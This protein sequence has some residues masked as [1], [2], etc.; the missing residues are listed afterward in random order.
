MGRLGYSHLS[1]LGNGRG[2]PATEEIITVSVACNFL[3]DLVDQAYDTRKVYTSLNRS[4]LHEVDSMAVRSRYFPS[5]DLDLDL[6]RDS[7]LGRN[8]VSAYIST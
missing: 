3:C 6:V 1:F 8:C 2:P 4:R 7:C 5:P